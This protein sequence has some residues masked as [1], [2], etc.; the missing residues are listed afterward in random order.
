MVEDRIIKFFARV[1]PVSISL[2]MTNF[3][4]VGVVKVTGRLNFL[5]NT[6]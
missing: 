6:C 3:S 2:V 1:G 5:A 4:Q